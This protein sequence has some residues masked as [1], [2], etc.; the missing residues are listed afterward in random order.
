MT[1]TKEV[2][3]AVVVVIIVLWEVIDP[4]AVAFIDS[5]RERAR[6]KERK[7]SR[8]SRAHSLGTGVR[9][10]CR[11]RARRENG[12]PWRAHREGTPKVTISLRGL[13]WAAGRL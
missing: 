5:W 6:G 1:L 11:P 9:H 8:G 13:V 2:L 10:V 3:G 4:E 7:C 12:R